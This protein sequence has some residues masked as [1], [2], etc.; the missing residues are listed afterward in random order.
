MNNPNT[1]EDMRII[2]PTQD[3]LEDI[4]HHN[5]PEMLGWGMDILSEYVVAT[6]ATSQVNHLDLNNVLYNIIAETCEALYVPDQNIILQLTDI[7]MV[8]ANHLMVL[9]ENYGINYDHLSDM[10][11]EGWHGLDMIITLEMI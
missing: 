3:I 7:G 6:I 10:H 9:L 5:N 8:I 11:I 1:I 2:L 4:Q